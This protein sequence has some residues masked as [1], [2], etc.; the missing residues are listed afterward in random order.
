M[1]FSKVQYNTGE[2]IA[3][4]KIEGSAGEKLDN[5]TIMLKDFGNLANIIC[6]KYGIKRDNRNNDDD[7]DW[8]IR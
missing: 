4:L 8:A 1:G 6:K 7:L 3:K 2:A 5:W